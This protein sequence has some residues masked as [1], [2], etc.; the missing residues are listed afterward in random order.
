M[1][2]RR[3]IKPAKRAP[4]R[5]SVVSVAQTEHG[6]APLPHETDQALGSAGTTPRR[7]MKQAHDDLARG[8]QDTGNAP[9]L[10]A[11]YRRLKK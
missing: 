6:V 1:A 10:D 9:V 7:S 5:G 2:T 3:I 4:R 8:L 11:T